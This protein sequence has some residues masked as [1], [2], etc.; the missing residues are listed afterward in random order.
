[1]QMYVELGFEYVVVVASSAWTAAA[2]SVLGG[3]PV[4]IN[5]LRVNKC[6][7]ESATGLPDHSSSPD[8][9]CADKDSSIATFIVALR[10]PQ[11]TVFN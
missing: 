9:F 3:R 4:H 1:M 11:P 6:L 2:I 8:G 10:P 7:P 5:P